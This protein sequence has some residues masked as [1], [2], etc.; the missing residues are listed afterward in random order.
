MLF[1]FGLGNTRNEYCVTLVLCCLNN[2]IKNN[3][4]LVPMR[5]IDSRWEPSVCSSVVLLLL[6]SC[7]VDGLV[8]W[9][10]DSSLSFS[11]SGTPSSFSSSVV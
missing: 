5:R 11:S 9:W 8:V 4:F 2:R 10:C 1:W 3:L 6:T 7:T